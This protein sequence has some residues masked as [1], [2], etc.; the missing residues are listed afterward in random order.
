MTG[1]YYCGQRADINGEP[2]NL[3]QGLSFGFIQTNYLLIDTLNTLKRT[4][5]ADILRFRIPHPALAARFKTG[6]V[7]CGC[8]F[9]CGFC[10]N[11]YYK[12]RRGGFPY[13]TSRG[14]EP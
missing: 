2:M 7:Q 12:F 10:G 14:P 3:R 1:P 6:K 9:R 4:E 8:Q 11:G 5:V 13:R